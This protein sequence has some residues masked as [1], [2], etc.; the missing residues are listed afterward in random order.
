VIA[1]AA[2]GCDDKTPSPCVIQGPVAVDLGTGPEDGQG[3]LPMTDGQMVPLTFGAQGGFHVWT[4]I[5]VRNV[6]FSQ[7]RFKRT[8]TWIETGQLVSFSAEQLSLVAASD[9]QLAAQGWGELP[10]SRPMF[11]CPNQFGLTIPGHMVRMEVEITDKD[12]RMGMAQHVVVPM[13]QN[14]SFIQA[15][16]CQCAPM[17]GTCPDGGI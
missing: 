17:L 5:R 9:P 1:L 3:Y 11:M 12:G 10:T 15:C 7:M 8:A 14:N 2:P 13:C 16:M 4:N 6:C